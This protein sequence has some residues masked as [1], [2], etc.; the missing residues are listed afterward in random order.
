MRPTWAAASDQASLQFTVPAPDPVQAGE[1][2]SIQALAVNT[3]SSQWAAGSYYWVA[4]VYDVEYRF[5]TRTQQLSPTDNVPPG[6]VA[7][8]TLP[9][10]VPVTATGRRFYRVYLVKDNQQLLE[11]DY[12][13]FSIVEKVI[14]PTPEAVDYRVE[15]NVTVSL[16]DSSLGR[17]KP[18]VL[19]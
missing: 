1:N 10:L 4:E 14:P 18:N 12:K 8:V 13:A 7:A 15:G 3:G 5:L 17:W 6:G 9:F 19:H 11:S 2:L 16:K